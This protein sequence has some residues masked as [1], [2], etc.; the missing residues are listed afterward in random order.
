MNVHPLIV[1]WA[2]AVRARITA[3]KVAIKNRNPQTHAEMM[4]A[5]ES[6]ATAKAACDEAGLYTGFNLDSSFWARIEPL[7]K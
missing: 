7:M 3:T 1:A 2:K 5:Y 6:E 4:S